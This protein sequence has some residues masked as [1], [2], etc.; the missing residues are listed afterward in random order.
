MMLVT[1]YTSRVVLNVLGVTDYGIY[2]LVGGVVLMS[3]FIVNSMSN[4]IQ[5]YLSYE[6][7]KSE[8]A[9]F[10]SVFSNAINIQILLSIIILLL[11]ETVGLWFLNVQL[12]FPI[13]RLEAVQW[14]Y[15]FS[16]LAFIINILS[17]PYNAALVAHEKM[18]AFAYIGLLEVILKLLVAFL[19]IYSPID[20]L[21]YYSSLVCIVSIMIRFI[22][23][24]YCSRVL[25][26]CR[27]IYSFDKSLFF[28]ILTF[29]SWNLLGGAALMLKNQGVNVL[30]NIFGGVM[31]NASRGIAG[32]VNIAINQFYSNFR[33]AIAP[34]LVKAYAAGKYDDAID[35]MYN[36]ARYTFYLL[37]FISLPVLYNT[38][39]V[40]DIWLANVPPHAVNFTRLILIDSLIDCISGSVM[41]LSQATGKIRKYQIVVSSII[42]LNFP[43]SY[44]FLKMGFPVESVFYVSI[45]V[46]IL[47]VF[48]RIKI[49]SNLIKL[50]VKGFFFNVLFP[51]LKVSM[52]VIIPLMWKIA[53]GET[54]Y[55]FIISCLLCFFSVTVFVYFFGLFSDEKIFINK[56]IGS[57]FK[58]NLRK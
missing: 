14:V 13:E 53:V 8:G 52:A 30:L 7:G 33:I 16:V 51:I 35:L 47:V 43:I 45:L 18:K 3:S 24:L 23:Q 22:Y 48:A 15:Q 29:S 17:V 36:S 42:F 2:D 9:N 40:L 1:L 32:Q 27:Y 49:V 57:F 41:L 4:G 26:K 58:Y 10:Q 19:V 38:G 25:K 39:M 21:I 55:T 20:N 11:A 56:K 34:P 37:L 54:W 44:I 5:R 6:L 28:S 12:Q 46:T 31:I 50:S